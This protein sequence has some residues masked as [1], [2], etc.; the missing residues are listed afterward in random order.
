VKVR[1]KGHHTSVS[2]EFQLKCTIIRYLGFTILK[3]YLCYKKITRE[4]RLVRDV[5]FIMPYEVSQ[6]VLLGCTRTDTLIP[7]QIL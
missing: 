4:Y 5:D 7:K 3:T 2:F 6:S 1:A